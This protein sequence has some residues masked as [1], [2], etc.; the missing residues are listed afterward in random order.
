[1]GTVTNMDNPSK[2]PKN[3]P[4]PGSGRPHSGAV[5]GSGMDRRVEKKK[6][7]LKKIGWIGGGVL[8][9]AVASALAMQATGGRSL[10]VGKDRLEISEVQSGTF[11]D[12]IPVRARVTPLKTVFLDA[13]EGGR[14]ERVLVEDG[15]IVKAGQPIVELSNA[16][17]QLEVIQNEALV[18]EQ[19]NNLR[20]TE[21]GLERNRLDHKRNLVEINYE[22]TRLSR[23]AERERDL[24]KT[25]AVSQAKLDDTEDALAYYIAKRDVTVESQATDM[26]MQ[27][28]QLDFL[29]KAGGQL[30]KSLEFARG[31]LEALEVKAPVD[32]KLSGFNVEI[33]QSIE[34]GGRLGQIDDPNR[35]KLEAEI[36]EFYLN[37]VDLGQIA[38]FEQGGSDYA[39]QIAKIYPQVTGGLFTVDLVFDGEE[40]KAI[41]RGQTIQL[42]LTLGDASEARLIPNGA[43]FQ[44]TGGHWV[45]VVS[46]D[47]TEAVKRNVRLGRRNTRHIEV[48]DGL[49]LGEKVITSPYTNFKDMDRLKL[50]EK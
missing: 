3:N 2:Q 20:T 40:A 5:S 44:D 42:K 39:L 35:F 29:Q 45:F 27:K 26:R 50:G 28:Q 21:L 18:T 17:L 41:R 15:A 34:R 4:N 25:G 46:S 31:N 23:Q 11:E 48:L 13:I 9:V 19:L 43:F 24:I 6:L 38:T 14:V 49:D 12:F 7:P 8:F 47:G 22:I 37:R 1:M 30:E 32:G 16:G 10:K 36:D 33:G